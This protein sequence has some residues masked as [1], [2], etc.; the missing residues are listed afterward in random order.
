M[1]KLRSF[2][3]KY[4]RQ[5]AHKLKPVVSVGQKGLTETV[6][7]S[8]DEA[9]NRH[10][11]IKVRFLEFKEKGQKTE[12]VKQIESQTQSQ[13]VGILGHIA[14]IFRQHRNPEDRRIF[15][16][17]RENSGSNL[18]DPLAEQPYRDK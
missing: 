4:L 7:R 10:E 14:I 11:L 18:Q 2:Q 9:L 5:Q 17:Q 6:V 13:A 15:L 1:E 3:K 16:P 8:V 12:L